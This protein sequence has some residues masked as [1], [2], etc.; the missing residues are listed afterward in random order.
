MSRTHL[1]PLMGCPPYTALGR[2]KENIN[3]PCSVYCFYI[4]WFETWKFDFYI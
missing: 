3:L 1:P 2:G 4:A